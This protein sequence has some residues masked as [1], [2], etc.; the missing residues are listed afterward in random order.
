MTKYGFTEQF[1][2]H[3][4][5]TGLF[6]TLKALTKTDILQS[7]EK[8]TTKEELSQKYNQYLINLVIEVLKKG[9]IISE[10]NKKLFL[11]EKHLPKFPF[12]DRLDVISSYLP[13]D[14]EISDLIFEK[15]ISNNDD[16]ISPEP[17][18][19]SK[20]LS[21][22]GVFAYSEEI[23]S[24]LKSL[25]NTKIEGSL[26]DLG[27]GHGLYSIEFAKKYPDLKIF[28]CDLEKVV[29]LTKQN[30]QKYNLEDKINIFS[31]DFLANQIEEK[32]NNILCS[33]ILHK[34]KRDIVLEKVYNA[35]YSNGK[36]II[37]TRVLN[38]INK[39]LYNAVSAL[40]WYINKGKIETIDFWKDILLKYG[41]KNIKVCGFYELHAFIVGE[42]I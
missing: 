2:K 30:V 5:I 6:N 25:E 24:L 16:I 23:K 37:N 31:L 39:N 22:I 8:G 13:Q 10:L 38:T 42:T 18:W 33:N 19:N 27:A 15:L 12:F 9:R 20:R 28:A 7:L 29:P 4:E 41:F 36:I 11:N 14:N 26:L 32:Y 40:Y 3:R 17:N 34:E 35:L 21:K 1:K